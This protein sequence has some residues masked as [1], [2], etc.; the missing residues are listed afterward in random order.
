MSG[1][2]RGCSTRTTRTRTTRRGFNHGAEGA[3]GGTARGTSASSPNS[4]LTIDSESATM[5]CSRS[6]TAAF[7]ASISPNRSFQRDSSSAS[8]AAR[9]DC[10]ITIFTA[11]GD[12]AG[13]LPFDA[14]A[15]AEAAPLRGGL[16]APALE[17]GLSCPAALP[18]CALNTVEA[19]AEYE[20]P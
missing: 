19:S 7:S 2:R 16:S 5:E 1:N 4:F 11:F 13:G 17:P 14:R 18:G 15:L 20:P 10:L 12:R 3:G 8:S 9:P 6:L